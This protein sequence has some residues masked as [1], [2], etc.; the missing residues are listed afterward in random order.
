MKRF[1][2]LFLIFM[3]V[4]LLSACNV[5]ENPLQEE[6][7]MITITFETNNNMTLHP[8][9]YESG[10]SIDLPSLESVGSVLFRGW[11]FDEDLTLE[12]SNLDSREEDFTLYAKWEVIHFDI[13]IDVYT[14]IRIKH[15]FMNDLAMFIIDN[16]GDLYIQANGE[17]PL[18]VDG[19]EWVESSL[20]T[21]SGN[22][23]GFDADADLETYSFSWGKNAYVVQSN[24]NVFAWGD[25]THG[26]LGTGDKVSSGQFIDITNQFD[27]QPDETI[28]KM[29][30]NEKST[31]ALTSHGNLFAWGANEYDMIGGKETT[32]CLA[33]TNIKDYL[34]GQTDHFLVDHG[35]CGNTDHLIV[36][37]A[38]TNRNVLVLTN[39]HQVF[40]WGDAVQHWFENVEIRGANITEAIYMHLEGHITHM[41]AMPGG[42]AASGLYGQGFAILSERGTVLILGASSGS[43]MDGDGWGD[44]LVRMSIPDYLDPDDDGDGW[45]EVYEVYVVQD[46]ILIL[47]SDGTLLGLGDNSTNLISHKKGYD[48][49]KALS[50]VVLNFKPTT[51]AVSSQEACALDDHGSL[52]CWGKSSSRNLNYNNEMILATDYRH[53]TYQ[54]DQ[55]NWEG[56]A[57]DPNALRSNLGPIKWMAPE[58]YTAGAFSVPLK[59]YTLTR[60]HVSAIPPS[61]KGV[62][63][64]NIINNHVC[65][66]GSNDCDDSDPAVHPEA[67]DIY[68]ASGG[69][70]QWTFE[71]GID[72]SRAGTTTATYAGS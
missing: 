52:W 26:Q 50:E 32:E 25:N 45:P 10:E 70:I 15:L 21:N 59:V 69:V 13:L 47:L 48:H 68:M 41:V 6:K 8:L 12:A 38:V 40:V 30:G 23:N 55:T 17:N 19:L 58:S 63:V 53:V 33:P 20:S 34:C 36:D 60:Y 44:N 64:A 62:E 29:V 5:G 61:I 39:W 22:F 27:L 65:V 67:W 2:R 72:R 24:G 49:Y 43:D 46:T 16:Q 66:V 9:T 51:I 57:E 11:F 37:I 1:L 56:E 28:V 42:S 54:G 18:A 71:I 7:Q 31:F 14:E 3:G 4:I 35:L